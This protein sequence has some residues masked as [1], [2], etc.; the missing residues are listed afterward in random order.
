[1]LSAMLF[2]PTSRRHQ[3]YHKTRMTRASSSKRALLRIKC[4][5]ALATHICRHRS[6]HSSHTTANR[7]MDA[8]LGLTISPGQVRLQPLLSDGYSWSATGTSTTLLKKNLSSGNIW[9]YQSICEELGRSI[10]AV[11]VQVSK[12]TAKD[13]AK[14]VC[15]TFSQFG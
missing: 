8:R 7:F 3:F 13:K 10:E 1:M 11:P 15:S 5:E 4:R 12:D 14:E 2:L 6:Y 9:F